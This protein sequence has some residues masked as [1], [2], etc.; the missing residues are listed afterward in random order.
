VVTGDVLKLTVEDV[1]SSTGEEEIEEG[2][3]GK[4]WDILGGSTDRLHSGTIEEAY[5]LGD[6]TVRPS[7][8]GRLS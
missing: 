7:P 6:E 8:G 2:Y 3:R 1:T 5:L 4:I